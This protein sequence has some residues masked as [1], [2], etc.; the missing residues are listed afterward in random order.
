VRSRCWLG[1]LAC[2]CQC[3]GCAG[4]VAHLPQL[5]PG[6]VAAEERRQQI[7]QIR[8]YYAGAARVG[9]VAYRIRVANRAA[10]KERVAPQIGLTAATVQSL[11]RKYRSYSREALEISWTNPT[12]ISVAAGSPAAAAGIEAGDEILAFN[13][14]PVASTGTR[15]WLDRWL[16]RNGTGPVTVALR[17]DGSDRRT[18]LHPVI[19]CDVAV[20]FT[21][22]AEP[23]AYTDNEAIVIQSGILRLLRGDADL[24]T[25][26]GHE[27]A[28]VTMDH[29]DSKI[30]NTLFGQIGGAVIDGSLILGGVYTGGAFSREFGRAGALAYS[31][32]F[33]RE[34][35]YIGAYYAAR[36]GYDISGTEE[37]WRAM[38]LERPAAIRLAR[39]HP[40][41]PVRFVQ[42]QN[43]IVE[44]AD[45]KRRG[46]P[47]EPELKPRRQ[48]LAANPESG[49]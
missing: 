28:H 49:Y 37:V 44:I 46:V 15:R 10:C 2:L 21:V 6:A 14:E 24:A 4:P 34:A 3:A 22:R 35:D 16:K 32:E 26:I 19:G 27:L 20:N 17:R 39:T 40:T 43:V 23:N 45:K 42:M 1:A 38:A 12:V 25:I 47:L 29:H 9:D 11:P 5:D 30:Q 33:E 7:D 31:V 13:N 36:A 41:S 8:D 18:V 48:P